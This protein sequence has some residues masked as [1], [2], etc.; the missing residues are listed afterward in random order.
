MNWGLWTV[1]TAI[2]GALNRLRFTATASRT[3]AS[4]PGVGYS[5]SAEGG[6]RHSFRR[7]GLQGGALAKSK[8]ASRALGALL[9]AIGTACSSSDDEPGASGVAKAGD[10]ADNAPRTSNVAG[11]AATLVTPALATPTTSLVDTVD[12]KADVETWAQS[13]G[14][15]S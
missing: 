4:R 14:E 1:V 3:A 2:L 5:L 8:R 6:F 9:I 10:G 12:A 11:T 7:D 13:R 15:P